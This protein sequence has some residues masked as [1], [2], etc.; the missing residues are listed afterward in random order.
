MN[1]P[2]SRLSPKMPA[3]QPQESDAGDKRSALVSINE[4]MRLSYAKGISCCASKC[5]TI[6]ILPLIYGSL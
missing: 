2:L 5:V 6:L 4:G 3:I 1:M